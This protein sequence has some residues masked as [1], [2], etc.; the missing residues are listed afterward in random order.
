MH[1]TQKLFPLLHP[2]LPGASKLGG[3][4]SQLRKAIP[5]RQ[6]RLGVVDMET[7]IERQ[8]GQGRRKHVDQSE[9]WMGGHEMTAAFLAILPLTHWRL[10]EHADMLGTGR[11]PHGGGVP[12][13]E[14]V[15]GTA[16]PRAT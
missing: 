5:H 9:R 7:G 8:R 10:L 14:R 16:R 11:D 2:A 1:A 4:I 15:D 3:K 13:G 6:N 12:G